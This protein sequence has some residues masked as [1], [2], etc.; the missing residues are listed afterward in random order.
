MG[1]KAQDD[2]A[3]IVVGGKA[4][5]I[6]EANISGR[7]LDDTLIGTIFSDIIY[8]DA[9]NDTLY[10]LDGQDTLRGSN[11]N[12]VLYGGSGD[13][14]LYGGAGTNT[15]YLST[16][17]DLII[18]DGPSQTIIGNPFNQIGVETLSAVFIGVGTNLS[19]D[20]MATNT[21]IITTGV[22]LAAANLDQ[23]DNLTVIFNFDGNSR[24][25]GNNLANT[26][27]SGNGNDYLYG[28]SGKDILLG[29]NGNDTYSVHRSGFNVSWGTV[30]QDT[31]GIDTIQMTDISFGSPINSILNINTGLS[32]SGTTLIVDLNYD[33]NF[34]ST[35]DL[36]IRDF[37][38]AGGV[39]GNGFIETIA[40]LTGTAILDRF[41]NVRNDFGNDKNSDILWRN[42]NG[43]VALWQMNGFTLT[44]GNIVSSSVNNTWKLA[45]TSDFGGNDK[46]DILWRNDN[47]A[48]A[49]W[50]V[51]GTALAS[52][53]GVNAV[54]TD[55]NI[56]GT[57]DF[58]GDRKAD[59]LWRNNNGTNAIWSMDGAA[60]ASGS[61][62]ASADSSWSV[63][64][65]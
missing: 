31:S 17:S 46:S 61:V 28:V 34:D 5:A 29:G 64:S 56:A 14:N 55:W 21:Q 52:A 26:I 1:L 3:V 37:F 43:D 15:I 27:N 48:N 23:I 13:D 9:G 20:L 54:T 58:N 57:G 53:V 51:D 11:D 44:A 47:G 50:F 60:L 22:E 2:H 62:I 19:I 65:K 59:I 12:D 36:S 16:G 33:G 10:G 4:I 35:N 25:I 38:G 30:I 39:A 7:P 24:L 41:R 42:S 18:L 8:G 32:K 63:V 40:N 49:M 6:E 45:G